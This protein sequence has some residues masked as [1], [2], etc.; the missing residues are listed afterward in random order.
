VAW[1]DLG[2]MRPVLCP[3]VVGRD[4]ELR[5][6]AGSLDAVCEG[7]GGAI[8]LSGEAGIGKSRLARSAE[9]LAGERG[10]VV[11]GGRASAV[12]AS[13]PYG[14]LVDALHASRAASRP[15]VDSGLEPYRAALGHLLPLWAAGLPA[16][17]ARLLLPEAMLR[18]LRHLASDAGALL[19]V[20]DAQWADADTLALLDH[21]VDH[22]RSERVLCGDGAF[23]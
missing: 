4:D 1:C 19:V 5:L 15:P 16:A 7:R 18:L 13:T 6:L 14:P 2:V 11:F 10:M 23:G 3:V 21:V 22:L 17:E 12:D 8:V 20:E 9:E